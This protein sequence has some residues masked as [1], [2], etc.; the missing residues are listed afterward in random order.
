MREIAQRKYHF[1]PLRRQQAAIERLVRSGRFEN[2]SDFMRRAIDHY[3]DSIG[4]PSLTQ[5]AREMAEEYEQ[6]GARERDREADDLQA[7]SMQTEERW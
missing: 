5:Q 7:P 2:V 3:L 6:G 1:A 4:R